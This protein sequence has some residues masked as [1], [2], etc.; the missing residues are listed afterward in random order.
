METIVGNL[1]E[2]ADRV[3]GGAGV[4]GDGSV[5]LE[6]AKPDAH[7]EIVEDPVEIGLWVGEFCPGAIV[8]D[9]VEDR[10]VGA[11][12]ERAKSFDPV[13]RSKWCA[14]RGEGGIID[15][16]DARLL[17]EADDVGSFGDGAES[18][19]WEVEEA[20]VDV[21]DRDVA[22]G[23]CVGRAVEDVRGGGAVA[24]VQRFE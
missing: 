6:M 20:V 1:G 11:G 14:G 10:H 18:G 3:G 8:S 13:G 17:A 22:T 2:Q 16:G 19:G 5:G 4:D 7:V 21:V 15:A 23:A 9:G 12:P 24:L